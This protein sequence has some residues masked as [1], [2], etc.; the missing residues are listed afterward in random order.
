MTWSSAS[1]MPAGNWFPTRPA[2]LPALGEA[3]VWAPEEL[4]PLVSDLPDTDDGSAAE[5]DAIALR[6]AEAAAHAR[7][8]EEE[9]ERALAD[10]YARGR[11][12]GEEAGRATEQV[13]LAHALHAAEDALDA[14]RAGESRWSGQ[15]EENICALSAAV[16]RQ[17][18]GRELAGDAA[19]LT[20][21]V[22]RAL[23]EFPVDQPLTIRVNPLDLAA[24]ASARPTGDGAALP[25]AMG[26][27]SVAPNRDTRWIADPAIEPGGCV[28]EGR[29]RIVDGRVDTALERIYR[30][31]T[32]NHA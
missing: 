23:A 22:R 17:V 12:D 15:V 7:A 25:T 1:S 16:A 10:A 3:D 9:H 8:L 32:G 11:A 27:A 31:L 2:L 4:T 18:I 28:V 13:R 24:M 30:Q 20:D 26:T 21:L 19:T 29:E 14:L 6:E 5:R